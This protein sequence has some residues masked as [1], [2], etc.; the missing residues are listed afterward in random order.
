MDHRLE[1]LQHAVCIQHCECWAKTS[2]LSASPHRHTPCIKGVYRASHYQRVS[3]PG[4]PGVTSHSWHFMET[5]FPEITSDNRTSNKLRRYPT[6]QKHKN[7]AKL[8]ELNVQRRTGRVFFLILTDCAVLQL[9][10]WSCSFPVLTAIILA[11]D[12]ASLH[13]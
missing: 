12:T 9:S 1:N 13:Q 6:I 3:Q 8:T 10:S 2:T 4:L 7:N 5:S 11:G